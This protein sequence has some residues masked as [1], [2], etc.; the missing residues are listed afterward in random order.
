[1]QQIAFGGKEHERLLI[2]VTGYERQ[3]CGDYHDDNWLC[4]DISIA[5]GA[6]RGSFG[7][8]FQ[9][10]ELAALSMELA[11]L[12]ET[13]SGSVKFETLEEQLC[14]EFIGNGRGAIELRGEASD[15]P[16]IG[17]KLSFTL[18]LDQTQLHQSVQ[19]LRAAVAAFPVRT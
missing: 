11:T 16:G 7:A 6:F 18:D 2:L 13:L 10:A 17:N 9:A 3:P 14:L 12:C 15:Q 8:T 4:V 1:M 5:A 19:N